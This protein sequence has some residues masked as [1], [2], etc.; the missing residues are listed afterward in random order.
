MSVCPIYGNMAGS[1]GGTLSQRHKR[2][3]R[4]AHVQRDYDALRNGG[5]SGGKSSVKRTEETEDAT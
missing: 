1:L 5:G 2:G 3:R 4:V